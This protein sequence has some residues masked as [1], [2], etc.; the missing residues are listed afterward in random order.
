[1]V[2]EV[3]SGEIEKPEV[4]IRDTNIPGPSGEVSI[5]ILRPTGVT[6]ALPRDPV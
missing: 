3:Q 2:D 6:G 1:V 4:E 5:R